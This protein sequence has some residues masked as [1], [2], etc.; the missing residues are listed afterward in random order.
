ME[1]TYA[2]PQSN[3]S[4]L[5]HN[6]LVLVEDYARSY[7]LLPKVRDVSTPLFKAVM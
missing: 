7:R 1:I 4:I 6:G 3:I 2:F 5:V